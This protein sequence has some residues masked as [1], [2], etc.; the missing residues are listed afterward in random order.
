KVFVTDIKRAG[1]EIDSQ[2]RIMA[3]IFERFNF[4]GPD[5]TAH[6]G[7]VSGSGIE[8][9]DSRSGTVQLVVK[10]YIRMRLAEAS[11]P[12]QH[13]RF[14]VVMT[15]SAMAPDAD[16]AGRGWLLSWER[17]WEHHQ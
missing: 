17:T 1:H 3:Y 5:L 15:E 14:D 2:R 12:F 10:L 6:N 16:W 7:D 9:A 13:Q 4:Y 8:R 11:L